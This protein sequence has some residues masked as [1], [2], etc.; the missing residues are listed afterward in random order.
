MKGG[1][2][3]IKK[4]NKRKGKKMR[5][6]DEENEEKR[7]GKEKEKEK[8]RRKKEK[9]MIKGKKKNKEKKKNSP[10]NLFI[11][12][13]TTCCLWISVLMLASFIIDRKLAMCKPIFFKKKRTCNKERCVLIEDP[14]HKLPPTLAV[15]SKHSHLT[16]S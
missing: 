12:W 5:I 6:E 2:D 15:R 16:N 3:K 7:G 11:L 8:Q 13:T 1:G 10:H 4:E 14:H 9:R